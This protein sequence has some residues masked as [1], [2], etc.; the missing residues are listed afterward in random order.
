LFFE[1][2][3]NYDTDPDAGGKEYISKWQY[4]NDHLAAE[5]RFWDDW[6]DWGLNLRHIRGKLRDSQY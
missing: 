5:S 2:M 6:D 4:S 1:E 3:D